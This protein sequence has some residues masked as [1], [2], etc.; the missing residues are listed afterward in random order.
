MILQIV[1]ETRKVNRSRHN[2]CLLTVDGVDCRVP[3]HGPDFASHKFAMKSGVRYECAVDILKGHFSWL[4]GPFPCGKW[5]DIT[6]F[7]HGLMH[8]LDPNERVEADD[9]Y[10]GEHPRKVKCPAGFANPPENE[11]M[12]QRVR[13]RQETLNKRL[14]QWEILN[15]PYRH[16]LSS[17][18]TV[19]RAIAVITQ[20]AITNGEPLFPTEDYMDPDL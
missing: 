10:V 5:P 13:N 4:N 12:Q 14:K 3:Q 19:F 20:V 11:A 18:G 7:R 15:V 16:E 8:H 2:D 17:H 1:F 6:I 9:G